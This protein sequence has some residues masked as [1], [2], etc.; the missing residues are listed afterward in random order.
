MPK[1]NRNQQQS[2]KTFQVNVTV[3]ILALKHLHYH[4]SIKHPSNN[5]QNGQYY[6]FEISFYNNLPCV[7]VIFI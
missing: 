2:E 7:D 5:D 3:I 4:I 6:V 1:K